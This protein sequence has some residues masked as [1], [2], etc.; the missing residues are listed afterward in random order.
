MGGILIFLLL[1]LIP[2]LVI[3]SF[4]KELSPG[5]SFFSSTT[6]RVRGE[7]FCVSNLFEINEAENE[8]LP[9]PDAIR[10][11]EYH[12]CFVRD[13]KEIYPMKLPDSKVE[14]GKFYLKNGQLLKDDT[15]KVET[16]L[17][18]GYLTSKITNNTDKPLKFRHRQTLT[19][20]KV[21]KGM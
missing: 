9:I 3:N 15:F 18:R 21:K 20:M 6:P 4:K 17:Y 11:L 14:E 7:P 5:K 10:R 12:D 2:L 8:L 16:K 19:R 13:K 1:V